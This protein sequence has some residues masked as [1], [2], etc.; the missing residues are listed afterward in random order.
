MVEI[1]AIV[2]IGVGLGELVSWLEITFRYAIALAPNIFRILLTISMLI[3]IAS[4]FGLSYIAL[5]EPD[6]TVLNLDALTLIT[7]YFISRLCT[8]WILNIAR[9]YSTSRAQDTQNRR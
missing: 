7:V 5:S 1:L 3:G 2:F 8:A 9:F 6:A 4:V